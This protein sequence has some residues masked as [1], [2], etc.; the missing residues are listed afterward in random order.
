MKLTPF[1]KSSSPT[2]T[3]S[4]AWNPSSNS[5]TGS[6]SLLSFSIRLSS[7]SNTLPK[8]PSLS[9]SIPNPS[10]LSTTSYNLIIDIFGKVRQLDVVWQLILEMDQSNI[11]P[12]SSTFTILIRRLIAA[13]LTRQA[14]RAYD[15][16]ECFVTPDN[17]TDSFSQSDSFSFVSCSIHLV[18]TAT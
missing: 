2:T 15:D 1:P 8:L 17:D 18:N 12:D 13:G 4:T 14:I 10:L 5:S 11:T 3:L 9:S 7:V 16:I 6:P